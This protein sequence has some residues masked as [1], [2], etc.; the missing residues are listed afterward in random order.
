M[1]YF[2]TTLVFVTC[3]SHSLSQRRTVTYVSIL[4]FVSWR[5]S[6]HPQ[7]SIAEEK[8]AAGRPFLT[9]IY[10]IIF[11]VM[12][13]TVF[14]LD[15]AKCPCTSSRLCQSNQYTFIVSRSF[16]AQWVKPLIRPQCLLAWRVRSPAWVQIQVWKGVFR[17]DWA[18][19]HA[20]R[21]NSGTGTEGPPV[22]SLNCDRPLHSGL[23]APELVMDAG[24]RDNRWT[25]SL[26]TS[27]PGCSPLVLL[28]S[29][30]VGSARASL[31]LVGC[32]CTSTVVFQEKP[33]VL[34]GHL[35]H[36]DTMP[37]K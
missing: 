19:G 35:K 7:K 18:S 5:Q 31:G 22:S 14:Y 8:R 9:H 20:M 4:C 33:T 6:Q 1:S 17:L 11:T 15:C 23:K 28:P 37:F 16:V 2:V 30:G 10:H 24:F 36:T 26:C 32:R 25:A 29:Q 13:N 34:A 27:P 12:C 21:L 3:Y